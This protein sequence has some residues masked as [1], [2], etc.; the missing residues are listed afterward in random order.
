[1]WSFRL[2]W[3]QSDVVCRRLLTYIVIICII[4]P[5]IYLHFCLKNEVTSPFGSDF[6]ISMGVRSQWG[7]PLHTHE[8]V[9][10]PPFCGCEPPDLMGVNAQRIRQI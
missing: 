1:M 8:L 2:G 9:D 7:Q 10:M 3:S 5:V 6:S 4:V